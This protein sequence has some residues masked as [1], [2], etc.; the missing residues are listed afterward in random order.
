MNETQHILDEIWIE[1]PHG[2]V[3]SR[4]AGDKETPLVLGIHGWSQRNG[5][6]S[7]EA[8]LGP[9][10][11]A[12]FQAVSVDMPGWGRSVAANP[13]FLETAAAVE[14]IV[15]LLD[16][17]GAETASLMGKSWGG[18]VALYTALAHP[19][20]VHKLILSAPAFPDLDRLPDVPHPVLLVWA[21]D[22]AM[23]PIAH[24]ESYM[25]GLPDV[26]LVRYPAGGHSAAA[27]NADE[28]APQAIRFLQE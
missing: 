28:F 14:T 23:I 11:T 15:A 19:G 1:T 5:W 16:G 17:L 20:R 18:G 12:G 25:K 13:G 4:R 10:G 9:L 26:R 8:L 27:K 22:D 3:Y 21:E 2:R 7:W 6:Q 24:A